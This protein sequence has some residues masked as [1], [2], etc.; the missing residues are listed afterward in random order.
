MSSVNTNNV[1]LPAKNVIS[2]K[3][4]DSEIVRDVKTFDLSAFDFDEDILD[5]SFGVNEVCGPSTI[6]YSGFSAV[7]D[8]CKRKQ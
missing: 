1:G 4:T 8:S 7:G 2:E 5:F 3:K 6:N